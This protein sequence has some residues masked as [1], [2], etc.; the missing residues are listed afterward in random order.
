MKR[1]EERKRTEPEQLK[2]LEP[3]QILTRNCVDNLK[4]SVRIAMLWDCDSFADELNSASS[5]SSAQ[6][7]AILSS[8]EKF[9]KA[10]SEFVLI[11]ACC[12]HAVTTLDVCV[13]FFASSLSHQRTLKHASS[14]LDVDQNAPFAHHSVD[15]NLSLRPKLHVQ[16]PEWPCK[17]GLSCQS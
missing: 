1:C 11:S 2:Q 16:M 14:E 9:A 3:E 6:R 5:S 8:V 4:M 12:R 17:Q 15:S 7:E 10:A 13:R